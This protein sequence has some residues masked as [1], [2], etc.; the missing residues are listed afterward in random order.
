VGVDPALGDQATIAV[1]RRAAGARLLHLAAHG[2]LGPGGAFVRLA[3]GEV[4]AT[5]VVTWHLAPR[6]VVLA[7]CASGARPSGS[8]W[9]ALGGAF[10]AAGSQAV[11][12]TLW[13]VEDAATAA[14]VH[15]FYAA[16]GDRDP[17]R[18]LAAAQRQAI[19][20]GASPRQW[21]AFV[22]LAAPP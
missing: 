15:A 10:L 2:G 13:S 20:T 17:V 4:T 8:A 5:D 22:V 14:L 16:G 9:G 21:T 18:A 6:T 1:L 19:A 7:S 3:D 11:V 12:A